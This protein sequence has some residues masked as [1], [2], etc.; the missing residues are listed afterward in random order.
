[1]ASQMTTAMTSEPRTAVATQLA[2]DSDLL[3]LAMEVSG[4]PTKK[5]TFTKALQ[6]LIKRVNFSLRVILAP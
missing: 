5:A 6:E 2:I 4:E 1:M 3:A